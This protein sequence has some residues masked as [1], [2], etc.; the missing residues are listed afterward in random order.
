MTRILGKS[1]DR[2]EDI[3]AFLGGILLVVAVFSVVFQVIARYFFGLSIIWINEVNE[4]ILLYVP[5][6][7]AAWLLRHNG[8]V[9][10]DLLVRVLPPR[11]KK[12]SNI[13][14]AALGIIISAVLVWYGTSVTMEAYARGTV[15]TTSTQL[16]LVY[17][18]VVIPVGSLLLL[19]EFIRK[20]F[21]SGT[22]AE[23]DEYDRPLAE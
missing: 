5:F 23:P 4:Y 11:I 12:A 18:L 10:V 9:T 20:A 2:I 16:P 3:F 6:L 22:G 17:L 15:S 21:N 7:G 19:F 8:H 1:L 14:V 13:L